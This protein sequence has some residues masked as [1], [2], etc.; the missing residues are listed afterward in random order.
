VIY[1]YWYKFNMIL[2]FIFIWLVI[3]LKI[4]SSINLCSSYI[5]ITQI[6]SLI[7]Y[8]EK[9]KKKCIIIIRG[10]LLVI[11]LLEQV[12]WCL[13]LLVNSFRQ[14]IFKLLIIRGIEDFPHIIIN[15]FTSLFFDGTKRD[16][17]ESCP[18]TSDM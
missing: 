16:L 10:I 1:L 2:K 8:F 15:S 14:Q 3:V 5:V 4:F 6:W 13:F 7:L 18:F 9:I 12:V 11:N 17:V